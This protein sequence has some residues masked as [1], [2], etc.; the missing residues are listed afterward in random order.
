MAIGALAE[1]PMRGKPSRRLGDAVAVAHPDRIALA[2]LPDAV[3]Q[4][5]RYRQLDLGAAELAVMAGLDLA[6]ELMRHRL[7]AVADAEHRHAGLVD[8]H[9]AR[10]ARPC[11]APRPAR[12]RG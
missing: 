12:R 6:A 11:R 3:G 1:V 10:A 4:R 9:R 5:R 7:L 8:R 2:D